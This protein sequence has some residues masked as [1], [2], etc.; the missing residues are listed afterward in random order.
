MP[1][2]D[3]TLINKS[4]SGLATLMQNLCAG[5][6]KEFVVLWKAEPEL[7]MPSEWYV[8]LNTD[9]DLDVVISSALKN[10]P[11]KAPSRSDLD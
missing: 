4:I 3:A 10:A 8:S 6:V 5:E 11:I 9:E 1:I 2:A 7:N